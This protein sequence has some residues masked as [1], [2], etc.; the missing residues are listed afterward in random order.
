MNKR[1]FNEKHP[2]VLR[3][4]LSCFF[5]SMYPFGGEVAKK[6]LILIWTKYTWI[7]SILGV[8]AN[9][10]IYIFKI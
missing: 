6:R 4:P 1:N 2:H 3:V 9:K 8:F 5:G 10:N 7:F